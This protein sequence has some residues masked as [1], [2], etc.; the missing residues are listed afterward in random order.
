MIAFWLLDVYPSKTTFPNTPF[1]GSILP[2]RK[3]VYNNDLEDHQNLF[4]N[5]PKP[6][7]M[8]PVTP[9]EECQSTSTLILIFSPISHP[10]TV[11]PLPTSQEG[12]GHGLESVS[13]LW[14]CLPVINKAT[15]FY[16]FKALSPLKLFLFSIGEQRPVFLQQTGES[17][18]ERLRFLP[19]PTRMK[20]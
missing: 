10:K 6:A 4:W 5:G 8:I 13:L 11:R 12:K 2:S 14:P 9:R 18:E 17:K 19:N 7:L 15:L 3:N 16:S 1:L 20:A